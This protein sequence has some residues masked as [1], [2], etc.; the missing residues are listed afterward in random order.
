MAYDYNQKFS[1]KEALKQQEWI[2]V[3]GLE[4][5]DGTTDT[6]FIHIIDGSLHPWMSDDVV[7]KE[8]FSY[9]HK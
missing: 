4:R 3:T 8:K 5:D 7:L 9:T 2:P 6:S 1:K